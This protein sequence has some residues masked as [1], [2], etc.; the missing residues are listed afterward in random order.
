MAAATAQSVNADVTAAIL[1]G[2]EGR[3]VGGSDKGLLLLRDRPL[4]AWVRERLEG[5][6]ARILICANRNADDYAAYGTVVG[7]RATGFRGPLAGIDAALAACASA[8]LLTVPVDSPRVP[9]DLARRLRAAA[10]SAGSACAAVR[11]GPQREPLFAIYRGSVGDSVADALR[12]D[13]A[14][15]RWQDEI[16]AVEADFSDAA[17]DFGN[18]N[19]T[20]EF[21]AWEDGVG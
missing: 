20:G 5:Q 16:G 6:A 12:R 13:L 8:W 21:R 19:T 1:A 15:W 18:L 3:R 17:A 10:E 7:D 11:I 14:V 9:R 4:I 2:G